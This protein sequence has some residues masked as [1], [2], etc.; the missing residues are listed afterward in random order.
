M[1]FEVNLKK[2]E[3]RYLEFH[4]QISAKYLNSNKPMAS[5]LPC[6]TYAGAK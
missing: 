5:S 6:T 4:Y 2:K 1:R 3:D